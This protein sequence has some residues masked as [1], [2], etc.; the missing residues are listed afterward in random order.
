MKTKNKSKILRTKT[1]RPS[2]KGQKGS[3]G[4]PA[5]EI[6][7][8]SGP[9]TMAK[10]FKLHAAGKYQQC[11]LTLRNKVE[12]SV[13]SG[14]LIALTPRKQKGGAVGRPAAVY[15]KADEFD[16]TKHV[17]AVRKAKTPK[18]TQ[19]VAVTEPIVVVETVAPAAAPVVSES[20]VVPTPDVTPVAQVSIP[21]NEVMVPTEPVAETVPATAELVTA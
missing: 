17:K 19:A 8:P 6:K 14:E 2:L 4:A 18:K 16:K 12:A 15:I 20:A 9:F 7:I 21:V 3:V 10:L 5:K 1:G 13:D 11:H